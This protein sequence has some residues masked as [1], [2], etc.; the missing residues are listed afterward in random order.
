MK[1]SILK[2]ILI[3]SLLLNVS[4]LGTAAY[5]HFRQTRF[6]PPPFAGSGGPPGQSAPFGPQMFFG[7][8]SLKPEQVKL[9]QQKA[10][11]FH[12]SLNKKRQEVDRLRVSLIGLMRADH[13][14]DKAI[15]A[16]IGRINKEQ[17]EMQ[18]TV[19]SHMLEFKSMLDKDQQK[20]FLDM[21]D[22]AMTQRKEAVC[23]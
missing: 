22:G 16:T 9:F 5:T 1:D 10:M 19:V 15:E 3:I 6:G 11:A 12:G 23:P 18:R 8:L 2:Y 14:D 4:L 13:P 17:E 20:K 21:I 7:D